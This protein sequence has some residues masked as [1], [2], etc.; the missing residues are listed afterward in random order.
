MTFLRGLLAARGHLAFLVGLGLAFL[1]IQAVDRWTRPRLARGAPATA[2]PRALPLRAVV[3]A[4]DARELAMAHAA[5]SYLEHNTE[6]ATGLA[7][8]VKGYP[9]TTMWDLGSQLMAVLAAEDLGLVSARGAS[10]RLGRALASLVRLPLDA[11]GLPSKV[12]DTR[13]LEMVTYDGSLAPAGLGWSALDV[14]RV[15]APLWLVAFR[16]PEHTRAVRIV[17]SGWRLS[18]LTDGA[19]LRGSSRRADGSTEHHQ[20]GRLGYEQLAAKDLLGWGL[21]VGALLDYG[22]HT[23]FADVY[24][25]PVPQDDRHPRDHGG[26]RAPVLSEPW[27][28]DAI[29]NG[30]DA[31]TLPAARAILLAQ[32]HRFAVTGRL[33]AVSEDHLDRPPWFA[34]SSILDGDDAWSARAP[35]GKPAPGAFGLS[36][37]AAVGWG[38]LFEGAYPERL[39]EAAA[40]LVV[41]GEGLYAGRYDDGTP[42]RVLSLNTNAV[43]LE[44]LAYRI[45]GPARAAVRAP[46]PTSA[47]SAALRQEP[48]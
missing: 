21:P 48:R 6:P 1:T 25:Q 23:T 20:E 19:T 45:R 42:N 15:L 4:L 41:P 32:E 17:V 29:E 44:A 36:A 3:P 14:A 10:A 31:V 2:D 35:D 26:A 40:A 37:K 9:A 22:S 11:G 5:W 38:V 34:Y 33:T 7:S 16:H 28:L 13:T 27:I 8:S 47:T 12:Y 30:L 18:A 24:G 39:L 43:V 46:L